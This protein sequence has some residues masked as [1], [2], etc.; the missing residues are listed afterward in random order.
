MVPRTRTFCAWAETALNANIAAPKTCDVILI[1]FLPHSRCA[2]VEAVRIQLCYEQLPAA[3]S[4][5]DW[6][7]I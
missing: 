3:P 1:S 4:R 7:A 5:S 6:Q 2:L